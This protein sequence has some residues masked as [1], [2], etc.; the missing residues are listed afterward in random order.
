MTSIFD[1]GAPAA[2]YDEFRPGALAR[3]RHHQDWS[4]ADGRMPA[5]Y[6]SH[7]APPLFDDGPWLRQLLDWAQAL[8][9]PRAILI[10]SAHWETAPLCLSAPAAGTPL[11]YDFGGF[12]PRY[13]R[14]TYP[15]PD[16]TA[17]ARRVAGAMPDS[18]HVFQH[19]SRGLD[20]GAWVPLMA[21]YPL[22]DIPVLQ[23]SMPTQDPWRLIEIG[24]RLRPLRDEG[25][26]VIG[27]G[28]MTHG[29]RSITREMIMNGA[30]PAWSSD[31]DAWAADA[32][33]RGDVGELAAYQSRAP[34][35]P[36]AHPTADHYIPLF[37]TLGAADRPDGPVRTTIDGYMI[38]FS[39][40]SFQTGS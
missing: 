31:F 34:G 16:A 5:L 38:G 35:M 6:L 14:M 1:P 28:F 22:A 15:T 3:A 21:M 32:L 9:K 13:Y 26:L 25:I 37:V 39:K 8:P 17:L 4:P 33:G 12:H 10:V 18:D 27:S 29:L 24:S 2:A 23:L 36:Y 30:I 19:P 20:H 11:V 40:R 7:G